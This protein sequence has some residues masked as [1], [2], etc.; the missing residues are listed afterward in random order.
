M[1]EKNTDY[2]MQKAYESIFN[3]EYHT[4]ANN[5]LFS[6]LI[7]DGWDIIN[8][9]LIIIENKRLIKD[10]TKGR[11]QLFN[12]YDKL[13]D[14]IKDNIEFSNYDY[15]L[16]LGLGN[17]KKSFKYVIYDADKQETKLTLQDVY[18]KMQINKQPTFDKNEIHN[19]NQYLYDNSITLSK[20][21]KTLFV[22]AILICLKIDKEILSDYEEGTNNYLIADKMI[23]VIDNYYEDKTFSN[24]FSFI[25]KSIH[26]RH[27]YHIFNLLTVDIKKYGKDILNEFYSEFCAWDRNNDA[28]LGIVLTPD[29][30]VDLMI[31]K[32][33]DYY[34]QFNNNK[35]IKLID[36]CTGTGS[37]LIKGS[38][39]TN[40]LYGCECGDE[41]YSLAKCNFILN[42]LDYSN[43]KYESCFNVNYHSN[44]FDVSIINPPFSNRCQDEFNN[45]DTIGW[46]NY[47]QEQKFIM[48]QVE[49]LRENG[50]GCCIVPR[51]NFNNNIKCT[52]DF[53][54]VL[55]NNVQVLEIINCNSK[56]FVPNASVECAILIYRKIK[57]NDYQTKIIDY[58]D[59]G[60]KIKKGVR[61]YD[62]QP[63]T[64]EQ[65]RTLK[66][67]DDWN[68]QNEL[69]TIDNDDLVKLI[70]NYNNNY[71][72]AYNNLLINKKE[73]KQIEVKYCKYL[74]SD[75]IEPLKYKTYTYDKCSDG[76]IPFFVA[77][78][79][80][81]P[82]GYK[83][84]VSVDCDKLGLDNVLC[85]NKSGEGVIGYCHI[86]SGRF[87]CN[88]IVG[89]YKMK[90]K[91]SIPNLA[92]LQHQLINKFNHHFVS[93]SLNDIRTT[94]V[95]LIENEIKYDDIIKITPLTYGEIKEWKEIKISD[96]FENVKVKPLKISECREGDYPLISSCS[97]NNGIGKFI[98]TYSIEGEFISVARNGSVGSSFYQN[99]QI[100]ITTD[101]ILLKPLKDINLHL[102]AMLL[103]YYLPSKYSYNNKLT[104]NKLMNEIIK[105]PI[106]E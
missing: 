31:T 95:F 86:R 77:S 4:E 83:D 73:K 91:L 39:Y 29:D 56:V 44:Y 20:S 14:N 72:Y 22:A 68:Y 92:I 6:Q 99:G 51:S 18:D 38:K 98:N 80:N 74:L 2:Y 12:Y 89:C 85:I 16:I 103:N 76:D 35:D 3:H 106:F 67:D 7:P 5:E 37:F 24:M 25:K 8:D 64:K 49:L 78:Q 102:M 1:S 93:L 9:T 63:I 28:L 10:K 57:V 58:S 27:I 55:L 75:I 36:F 66:Y 53:K 71:Q 40:L 47:D 97:G 65:L 101:I 54:Q 84:V 48:Y 15:Y 52:N 82:K 43:L 88:G 32:S 70:E 94:E 30:I 26:N 41:R 34:Y 100:S 17:N 13:R 104:I 62:H 96:Y 60:Y 105:I 81:I 79:L 46:R 45:N 11:D 23:S 33:F 50:I 59:D 42:N 61:Y 90:I 87:G 19:L 69:I 21:Q